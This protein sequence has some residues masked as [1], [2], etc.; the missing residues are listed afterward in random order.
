MT[1]LLQIKDLCTCFETARGTVHAVDGVDLALNEGDT[2]GIAGESGCGKTVLAL[3]IMR[4]IPIPPGRIVSGEILFKETDL[5]KLTDDE[6]RKVRGKDI[7]MIFQEPMTSL[8]PVFK[9]GD[10]IA[11]VVRLHQGVSR[12]EALCRAIEMLRLVGMPSPET[13]VSDYPHQMSGG[14]RQR[15]MIA[16]ALSCNPCL[17]LADE[18]TTALDVTIQAQILELIQKLKDETGTSVVLITHDLG[19]IAEAAQFAAIMYAGKIVEYGPVGALLSQPLHPYTAGLMESIPKIGVSR[20][21]SAKLNVIRGAVP[22]LYELPSGC[23][24]QERCPDRKD[25]CE[26]TKPEM[27]EKSAGHFVRCWK[28]S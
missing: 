14:M 1:S 11:E 23:A 20:G 6:M 27:I 13:R 19:V 3:S 9:V 4:L 26:K 18:P 17:M 2:L 28:Y 10:Q 8:N 5:L 12:K 24:F 15:V 25:V 22:N 7:S 21:N 16:M